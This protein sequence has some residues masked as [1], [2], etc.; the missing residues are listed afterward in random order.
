MKPWAAIIG[1]PVD[2]SLSPVLHRTAYRE[3]GLDWDYQRHRVPLNGLA[4]FMANLKPG[5]MGLSV[6]SPLKSAVIGQVNAVDGLA[7]MLS[8]ANTVVPAP[9]MLAA[10]NTDVHGIV[11]TV[12]QGVAE[13]D[14]DLVRDAGAAQAAPVIV[15]TGATAASALAA[16]ATLGFRNASLV[17]RQFG[18]PANA[19]TSAPTLD[20]QVDPI[21]LGHQARVKE[22]LEKAPLVISTV[23][24]PV[25]E[26]AV[27]G[28]VL[29]PD[30][31]VLDVTYGQEPSPLVR[32]ATAQNSTVL[33]PL[34]MLVHQGL[35]QVKLMSNLE[36]PY[37]P[38]YEAVVSAANRA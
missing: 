16:L 23:P 38:V 2:H 9:G 22:A 6:T 20:M 28:V 7:K 30:A 11:E 13:S 29:R 10:F 15:G 33:S 4:D 17:G 21:P 14:L 24:P 5:F 3:L 25:L 8:S 35:A 37:A 36:A 1:D 18:G 32:V 34:A 27:E 19:F 31:S 26:P 12:K